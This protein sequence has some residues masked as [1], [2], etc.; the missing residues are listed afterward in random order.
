MPSFLSETV[1]STFP[2][3]LL[4]SYIRASSE[5]WRTCISQPA[6]WACITIIHSLRHCYHP[7]PAATINIALRFFQ[8]KNLIDLRALD[9]E[10]W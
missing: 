3:W 7:Q 1:T 2:K 6:G 5:E 4:N 10:D 9:A 8:I